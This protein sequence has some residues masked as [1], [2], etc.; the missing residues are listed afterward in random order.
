MN[1]ILRWKQVVV[2]NPHECFGCARTYPP[3]TKMTSSAYVDGKT[4]DNCCWCDT[5]IA[6]MDRHFECGEETGQGDIYTND[7]EGWEQIKNEIGGNSN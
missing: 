1:A 4:V 6:Y 2:R 7:K 3:K 5:C